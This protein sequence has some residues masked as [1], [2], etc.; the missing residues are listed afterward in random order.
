M[1][2]VLT[3]KDMLYFQEE[4]IK[5]NA[6][7]GNSVEDQSLIPTYKN[8]AVEELLGKGEL[9]DSLDAKDHEGICD[10]LVDFI[11]TAGFWLNLQGMY[12]TEKD[13]WFYNQDFNESTDGNFEEIVSLFAD[14]LLEDY[15][16]SL[17]T[18]LAVVLYLA[19]DKYDIV[20]A[21]NRILESN[22]SKAVSKSSGICPHDCCYEVVTAGRYTEV[23]FED[24]GDFYLIKAHKDLQEGT[25]YPQGKI[26]KGS[27]YHSVEELGGLGEFIY[28]PE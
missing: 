13:K 6:L 14:L 26:V 24:K 9:L 1:K 4:V 18:N 12:V 16:F 19:A 2:R 3:F 17:Q 8:L 22:T 23:F 15:T 28:V 27:W 25:D 5:W 20:G 7:F 10:G 21:F 11:F